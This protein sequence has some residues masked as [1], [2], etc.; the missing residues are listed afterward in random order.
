MN[1][2]HDNDDARRW[3]WLALLNTASVL[4]SLPFSCV[5]PFVALV[6]L[7][8]LNM[9]RTDAFLLAGAVFLANQATGF[10]FLG[11]SLKFSTIAWGVAMGIGCML[12]VW[13]AFETARYAAGKSPL[14]RV[15]LTF[16]AACLVWQAT[17]S[18]TAAMLS[19]H[20]AFNGR[21]IANMVAINAGSLLL[22]LGLQY[23]GQRLGIAPR[24]RHALTGTARA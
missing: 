11:Y 21:I 17:M 13:A 1:Y 20:G 7:A 22:L 5:A 6:T 4:L 16:T 9:N 8:G 2:L 24:A 10:G 14:L 3:A 18:V 19:P 23:A 12:A 15:L